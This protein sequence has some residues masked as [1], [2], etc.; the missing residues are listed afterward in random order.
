LP[1]LP[2]A[3][4]RGQRQVV[5][6]CQTREHRG[7]DCV[8]LAFRFAVFLADTDAVLVRSASSV[9]EVLPHPAGAVMR[10]LAFDDPVME[11]L[12]CRR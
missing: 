6:A 10:H 5:L 4:A 12:A 9:V 7:G 3:A 11:P 1:V 2:A 8:D